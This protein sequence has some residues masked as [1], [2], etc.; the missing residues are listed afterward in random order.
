[1]KFWHCRISDS[2]HWL[3]ILYYSLWQIFWD[4]YHTSKLYSI[5]NNVHCKWIV[6][7]YVAVWNSVYNF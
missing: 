7:R 2:L 6:K 4:W 1:L 5:Q 3:E